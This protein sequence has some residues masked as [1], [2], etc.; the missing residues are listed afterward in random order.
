[1]LV[2]D[3]EMGETTL[4]YGWTQC[5][6][7]GPCKQEAGGS[8]GEKAKVRMMEA[9]RETGRCCANGFKME[10]G[11]RSQEMQ[12]ASEARKRQKNGCS[13]GAS[14]RNAAL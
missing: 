6:H 5:N 2:K 11:A 7:K 13:P 1:M 14:R 9:V 10:D 8:E 3:L 4:L 12:A